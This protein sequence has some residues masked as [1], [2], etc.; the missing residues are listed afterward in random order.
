MGYDLSGEQFSYA[1]VIKAIV[2]LVTRSLITTDTGRDVSDLRLLETTRIYAL[3]KLA[4]NDESERVGRRHADLDRHLCGWPCICD[5]RRPRCNSLPPAWARCRKRH[6]RP[7]LDSDAEPILEMGTAIL[8]VEDNYTG[9]LGSE[10]AEASV[11][12]A[13]PVTVE[14]QGVRRLPKSGRSADDVLDYVGLSV[15][16]I[17][18]A[19]ERLAMAAARAPSFPRK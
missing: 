12:L 16:K 11:A 6:D 10:L 5:A 19:A 15:P 14:S 8:A 13:A 3:Q 7:T 18:A 9:G 1:D 4:D 17:A 2:T